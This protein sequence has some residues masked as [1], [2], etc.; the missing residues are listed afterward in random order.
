[1]WAHDDLLVVAFDRDPIL[2][3]AGQRLDTQASRQMSHGLH[4]KLAARYNDGVEW[5]VGVDLERILKANTATSIDDR[6]AIVDGRF[7]IDDLN[8][9]LGLSLPEDEEYDTI[10][11]FVLAQLGRVP[12]PGEMVES[13]GARFTAIE[14][15][16]THIQRVRVEL[17]APAGN[18]K[19]P[20]RHR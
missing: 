20:Q 15:S 7:H 3:L 14:A 12:Q 19:K 6:Q 13:D 16:S 1:M 5:L 18:K 11:G 17:L 9:Q 8:E 2:R 10:A 4:A